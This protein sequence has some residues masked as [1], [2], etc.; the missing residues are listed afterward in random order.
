MRIL[1]APLDWGLGHA[2]RCI[3]LIRA[4]TANG[5]TVVACAGGAGERLLRAEFPQLTVEH[6]SGHAMRYTKSRGLLPLWLLV[7]L[8]LFLYGIRRDRLA[9]KR[10][11][12]KHD[13]GLVISD[14]R[15]GFRTDPASG[16]PTVFISHQIEILPPGPV[17]LRAVLSPLL[18]MLNRR[19]LRGFAEVWIPDFPGAENLSGVLGHPPSGHGLNLQYI[20][21]LCR[22]RSEAAP[23]NGTGSEEPG[24][25]AFSEAFLT[26][27]YL[28]LVSGPE[29]QRTLFENAL[30]KSLSGLPGTKV[31]VRGVPGSSSPSSSTSAIRAGE[32]TVFDHLP[33]ETLDALLRGAHRVVCRSGYTTIMELAGICKRNVLLV[34]TPGQPEQESLAVHAA[35]CGF[36]VW[37]DQD[38]LDLVGGFREASALP[39]FMFWSDSGNRSGNSSGNFS[40]TDWV[41]GHGLLAEKP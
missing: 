33:G 18:R 12:R 30:R 31:L 21:P 27:D 6:V 23:W 32:L 22:F 40:L 7:Q 4:L 37:Q 20:R 25:S 13:A 10:L 3:P 2:T 8:P 15:Y 36:A 38:R 39:G 1:I 24:A 16:V 41:A 14:G 29:P 19:A 11:A 28:A 17:W 34:P 5:H 35:F 26:I 9:A